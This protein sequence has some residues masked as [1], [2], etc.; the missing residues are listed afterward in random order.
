MRADLVLL[1]LDDWA[2]QPFNSAARQVVYGE[3]GRG[4]RHVLV[5]GRP[6]I[7]DGVAT[8]VDETALRA[9]IAELLVGFRRDFDANATRMAPAVPYLLSALTRVVAQ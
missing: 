1:D 2:Y 5:D 6:V 3:T 4:L 8:T 7:R 9:E